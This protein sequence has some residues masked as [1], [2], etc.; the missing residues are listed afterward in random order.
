MDY[1]IDLN[2]A[3]AEIVSR[4]PAWTAAGLLPGPITWRDEAASWPQRLEVERVVITDP[5][6]VGV[7]IQSADE[8][9][10]VNIVLYRGGWVDL[11]GLVNDVITAEC[12]KIKSAEEFGVV[13]DAAIACFLDSPP[14]PFELGA[15]RPLGRFVS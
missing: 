13:L 10:V 8:R 7:F 1:V 11:D 12:P 9:N 5:D 4:L 15:T 6:S 3:A 14:C 2:H